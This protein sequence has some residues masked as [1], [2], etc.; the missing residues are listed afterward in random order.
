MLILLATFLLGGITCAGPV[1]V[2]GF[3][4]GVVSTTLRDAKGRFR[5]ARGW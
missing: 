3:R 5:R 1:Y 2:Y 4:K